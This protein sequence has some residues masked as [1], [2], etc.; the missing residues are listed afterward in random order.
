MTSVPQNHSLQTAILASVHHDV[1]AELSVLHEL[2]ALARATNRP[3][4][5]RMATEQLTR[6]FGARRFVL[7]AGRPPKQDI[8]AAFGFKPGED[9]PA[10]LAETG[11]RPNSLT[12]CFNRDTDKQDLFFYEQARPLNDRA[13]RFY[14]VLSNRVEECLTIFR[15]TEEHDDL[16]QSLRESEDRFRAILDAIPDLMFIFRRDG[17][18]LDY[19]ASTRALLAA[20]PDHFLGRGIHEILPPDV[21]DRCQRA[22][23]VALETNQVQKVEYTLELEQGSHTFEA[24]ICPLDGQRLLTIVRDVSDIRQLESDRQA[25]RDSLAQA[26]KMESIGQLAGGIAHDFNN[27][28]GAILAH[29]ELAMGAGTSAADIHEH[30]EAIQ[31]AATHSADLTRQLLSFARRQNVFPRRLDLN[32]TLPHTLQIL[33]RLIGEHI[34]LEWNPGPPIGKVR[35]DP[36]QLG[37]IVTNLCVNARDAIA[38][39]RAGGRITVGTSLLEL[40]ADAAAQIKDAA[41]GR[42]ACVTVRDN[43]S[44]MTPDILARIF[45]PFYTTRD[46]GLGTGLGLASAY[47]AIRQNDGFITVESAPGRGS[48]FRVSFPLAT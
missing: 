33:R 29:V 46:L 41:P 4:L 20:P 3:Q 11:E 42:Y 15:H 34:Q 12:I 6:L 30:L 14:N 37:Q 19:H 35:V 45:E 7:L 40:D 47:G 17:V 21:A 48:T 25:L 23:L 32:Q 5:I 10:Y 44:G 18:Y 24:R 26:Q 43:G 16:L 2:S 39:T 36:T 27:M 1:V 38:N 31:Q 28:L 8:L 9:V 13:R 22:F